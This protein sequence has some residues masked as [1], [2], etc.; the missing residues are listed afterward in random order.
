MQLN[1]EE[2]KLLLTNYFIETI[3]YLFLRVTLKPTGQLRH[4]LIG[5]LRDFLTKFNLRKIILGRHLLPYKVGNITFFINT[6]S[7][8]NLIIS[9][10]L[11]EKDYSLLLFKLARIMEPK[12]FIDIGAHIGTYTLRIAKSLTSCEVISF[13]PFIENYHSLLCSIKFNNLTNVTIYPIALSNFEGHTDLYIDEKTRAAIP[14]RK[15]IL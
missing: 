11:H 2:F 7:P 13:E 8:I 14:L 12:T 1:V 15:F 10:L 3:I 4:K 6:S 9:N 5:G